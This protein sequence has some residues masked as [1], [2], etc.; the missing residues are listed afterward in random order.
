MYEIGE[1]EER[2]A[3]KLRTALP[4]VPVLLAKPVQ[5]R[6]QVSHTMAKLSKHSTV[7]IRTYCGVSV[8]ITAAYR[9]EPRE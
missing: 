3:A 1:R 5:R 4:R 8:M 2:L 6:E 7:T 9:A